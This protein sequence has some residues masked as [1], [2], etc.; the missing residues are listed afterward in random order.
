M[1]K[2]TGTSISKPEGSNDSTQA[3]DRENHLRLMKMQRI[4][5]DLNAQ[6]A[7]KNAQ[8][9]AL[10]MHLSEIESSHAWKLV[11]TLWRIRLALF[12]KGSLRTRFLM[13]IIG[14]DTSPEEIIIS[15]KSIQTGI[16][17][18][19]PVV[20]VLTPLTET[21]EYSSE[22]SGGPAF[23]GMRSS[24]LPL[25]GE[26][27]SG[28]PLDR[29]PWPLISVLLPV[30]NHADKLLEAARSVLSST[31]PRL[32]LVILD[33]G[34][35]DSIEDVLS[36]LLDDP[37]VRIFRQPNQTL[38]RALTHAHQYARGEFITWI[39]AEN[40]IAPQMLEVLANALL[41]HPEAV[42]VY[43]DVAVI[44]DSGKPML[45][46]SCHPGNI[47][48]FSPDVLRLYRDDRPLG[49]E[50]DNYINA[51]FL[52]RCEA[53]RVLEGHYADDLCGLEDYD[54]WL[55]LQKCG[56][57]LHVRNESPLY[58]YRVHPRSMSYDLDTKDREAH[59]A[60]VNQFIDYEAKRRAFTESRWSILLD[61]ALPALEKENIPKVTNS[62]P[63]DVVDRGNASQKTTKSIPF[64]PEGYSGDAPVRVRPSD[65]FW[66]L[67]WQ[68]SYTGKWSMLETWRGISLSPL[69]LKARQHRP[70]KQDLPGI[71]T[72]C[73]V[74]CHVGL[75]NYPID[76][77]LTRQMIAE[78]PWAYF[79]FIDIPGEND[80]SL[81]A[82]LVSGLDNG[83]YL[84][85][86]WLGGIYSI[87]AHFDL[88]WLPPA[89][90]EV[91]E[92]AYKTALA[93]AYTIARPF[94]VPARAPF[95]FAPY[96]YAY[97]PEADSFDFI[98]YLNRYAM[99]A[100]LLDRYLERWTPPACL[101]WV[102]SC[103]NE[104]MQQKVLPR[105]DFGVE[106]VPQALPVAWPADTGA[107]QDVFKVALGVET[108]DTGGVEGVVAQLASNLPRFGVDAFVLCTGGGG[109][110]AGQLRKAGIRVYLAEGKKE[111]IRA[112]LRAE[113]PALVNSHH[114]PLSLLEEAMQ[115]GLPVVETI[116]N[117]YAWFSA[118]DWQAEQKR[119]QYF[120][121]ALAVSLLVKE[122]YSRWNKEFSPE[123]IAVVGNAIDT[124]RMVLPERQTARQLAGLEDGDF[125]FL[126]FARYDSPKNLI[127][128][129][130]AFDE[131]SRHFP[132]AYL[133]CAGQIYDAAYYEQVKAF[134]E[135]LPSRERIQLEDFRSDT[136]VL[137]A[138]ADS[139]VLDSIM[140][141]WSLSATEALLVGLPLI[142]S[143][144]GSG[145]ELVGSHGE[146]GIL[147]PNPAGDPLEIDCNRFLATVKKHDQIN[148]TALVDA[149][150][151]VILH[152]EEWRAR[153]SS[154]RAY[155]RGAF[156]AREQADAYSKHFRRI[157]LER[158]R[159]GKTK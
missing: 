153:Q 86:K 47:D 79:V 155:A 65:T 115:A 57:L 52:Y 37:R 45:D 126:T 90:G 4:V 156:Q 44:D 68:S 38:P 109:W 114:A 49:Y 110:M 61:P 18:P 56:R 143:D 133:L 97:R 137:L 58:Y 95:T 75:K 14:K 85:E 102:L 108:L 43:A 138:A 152:Q 145:R 74:G 76:V 121:G 132:Q 154:T 122:Y 23:P 96:Q 84:G 24:T 59:F 1:D 72:R 101:N 125:I 149:M 46:G 15:N 157:V 99:D 5:S 20:P 131:V 32:E 81:G 150:S 51:C 12:P 117:T 147:V 94:V 28:W 73:V 19:A 151:S 71:G 8:L 50:P 16:P 78:A 118:S 21:I 2:E 55:R 9:A 87:Y 66:R 22:N 100:D 119:S 106:A 48:R 140:E 30:N 40:R 3:V 130:A 134:R 34:S 113:K 120:D 112:V 26:S 69:A 111:K 17:K 6:L 129:L 11:R 10:S 92:A 123:Q 124:S 136:G 77:T 7:S 13:K 128:L 142:H 146:R 33:D 107:S 36:E 103:A 42:L 91:P 83:V 105:P 39:S 54:F 93:L 139:F 29:F 158:S 64:I 62:L 27:V 67:E 88:F 104:L 53:A 127:G 98:R 116:H 135:E 89:S 25:T 144:C 35:T 80:P 63:V 148:K 141:G 82:K 159:S 60:H 70:N 31:Y 41:M